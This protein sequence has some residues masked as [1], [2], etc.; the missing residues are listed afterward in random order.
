M[1]KDIHMLVSMINMKLRDDDGNCLQTEVHAA[2]NKLDEQN[3]I[4]APKL[5]LTDEQIE[6]LKDLAE[7]FIDSIKK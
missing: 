2:A 4:T 3:T 5:L 7:P 1:P 6:Q